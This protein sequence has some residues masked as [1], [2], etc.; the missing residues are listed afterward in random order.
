MSADAISVKVK[1]CNQRGLHARA[2]AKLVKLAE[3][4]TAD[5]EVT[6]ANGNGEPGHFVSARS[7]LGLMMLGAE[8][9]SE[10]IIK[11]HG[12]DATDAVKALEELVSGKFGEDA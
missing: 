5:I 8:M 1:I 12:E 7:I 9:G 2:T 11:A 3:N 10:I 6:K 4:Y